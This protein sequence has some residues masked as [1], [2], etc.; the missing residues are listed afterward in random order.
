ML[1]SSLEVY[2]NVNLG[3]KFIKSQFVF[4]GPKYLLSHKYK[5]EVQ[6]TSWVCSGVV[7]LQQLVIPL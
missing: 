5:M 6:D 3:I 7:P 1:D 2:V 4:L